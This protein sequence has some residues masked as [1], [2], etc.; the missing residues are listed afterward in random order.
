MKCSLGISNF[1]KR[2][3]VFPI[4]LLSSI[5]LHWS[6]RKAFLCL[7]VILWN[8]AFRWIY[9]FFS[10]ASLFS[11]FLSYLQALLRQPFCLFAFLFL[12]DGF[13]HP[14]P[15]QCYE[16]TFIVLQTLFLSD[17]IPLIYLSLPLYSHNDLIYIIPEW[18]CGFPYFLQFVWFLQ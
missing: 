12:G 6:L 16:P 17:L 4:L 1:L 8:S 7:L 3:L 14:P 10:F 5:S 15:V 11:S 18:S 13:A 2:S 9:L